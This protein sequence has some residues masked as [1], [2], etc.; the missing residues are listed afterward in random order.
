VIYKLYFAVESFVLA[1]DVLS[2]VII[3][4]TDALRREGIQRGELPAE[5]RI[6]SNNTVG[7]ALKAANKVAS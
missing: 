4:V 7:G 2:E 1:S 6:I 3:R 5:V